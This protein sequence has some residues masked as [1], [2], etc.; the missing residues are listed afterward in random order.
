VEESS[1]ADDDFA[2]ELQWPADPLGGSPAE[3]SRADDGAPTASVPTLEPEPFAPGAEQP[4]PEMLE[5]LAR[6]RLSGLESAL[7]RIDGRIEGLGAATT[8]FRHA[9]SD[10]ISEYW[11][12][13]R[14]EFEDAISELRQAHDLA[15]RD[16]RAELRDIR[17][18]VTDARGDVRGL[19]QGLERVGEAT[20]SLLA[21]VAKLRDELSGR[22]EALA[23]DIQG[24]RR[25][26]PVRAAPAETAKPRRTR[27]ST[28]AK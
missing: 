2:V 6:E 23:E 24:V 28:T 10:R 14:R 5:R 11:V 25:R 26:L 8:A 15:I 20:S 4:A 18:D 7:G 22:V 9:V 1:S 13:I 19:A 27:G 17:S 12:D 3:P 16:V 21:E